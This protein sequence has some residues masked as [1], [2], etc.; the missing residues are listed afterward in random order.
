MWDDPG[1]TVFRLNRLAGSCPEM[2][3]NHSCEV[4]RHLE[5]DAPGVGFPW[6]AAADATDNAA[7]RPGFGFRMPVAPA[8]PGKGARDRWR[9]GLFYRQESTSAEFR[10]R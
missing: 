7:Y 4:S 9:Y 1:S 5:L 2:P 3:L 6:A 8:L 10:D